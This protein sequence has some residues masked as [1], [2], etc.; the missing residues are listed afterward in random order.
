MIMKAGNLL[1]RLPTD[2]QEEAIEQLLENNCVKVERIVSKGH[3]S[4]PGFWYDQEQSEWVLLLKGEAIV[5]VDGEGDHH[6]EPGSFLNL[7]AHKRHR[8]QWTSPDTETIWLAI[9]YVAGDSIS[10]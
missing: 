2:L 7:P 4:P 6:L 5:R 3:C 8:V 10:E 9:H 1:D